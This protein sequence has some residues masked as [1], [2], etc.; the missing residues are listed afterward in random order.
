MLFSTVWSSHKICDVYIAARSTE[1]RSTA[2]GTRCADHV[3]HLSNR[4][5][6]H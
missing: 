5:N 6:W 1:P 4:K 3:A 2:A